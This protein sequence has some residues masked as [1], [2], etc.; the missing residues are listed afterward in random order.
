MKEFVVNWFSHHGVGFHAGERLAS[1]RRFIAGHCLVKTCHL[2]PYTRTRQ[3]RK[4]EGLL[5]HAW[6]INGLRA[7]RKSFVL[8]AQTG[9]QLLRLATDG[10]RA[11]KKHRTKRLP[12]VYLFHARGVITTKC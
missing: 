10:Y 7:R 4:R 12:H 5:A 3:R 9:A 1:N 6:G 8:S 2:A 11:E